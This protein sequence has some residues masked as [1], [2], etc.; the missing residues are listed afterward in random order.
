MEILNVYVLVVILRGLFVHTFNVTVNRKDCNTV[1]EVKLL[2]KNSETD[3]FWKSEAVVAKSLV[4]EGAKSHNKCGNAAIWIDNLE[5][6][7]L[8]VDV[9][10]ERNGRNIIFYIYQII[11]NDKIY[12]SR[13]NDIEGSLIKLVSSCIQVNDTCVLLKAKGE[14]T[15]RIPTKTSQ[16]TST[17]TTSTT[18]SSTTTTS[19]TTSSA[20]TT[21]TTTSSPTTSSTTTTSTTT[22]STTTSSTTTSSATTSSTTTTSTTTS[23]TTTSSTTTSSAT[24]TSTTTSS[25]TASSTTTSYKTA[26]PKPKTPSIATTIDKKSITTLLTALTNTLETN[27]SSKTETHIIIGVVC[28][29]VIIL[30]VII[31]FII[32]GGLCCNKKYYILTLFG[33][34]FFDPC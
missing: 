11:H 10:Y 23:S 25:T 29:V 7:S 3:N 12:D 26:P 19:T 17:T 18:T 13:F 28:S 9:Q 33:M 14:H 15:Y 21:S 5:S 16:Q 27:D 31:T 2:S 32:R 24:A 8:N 6:K 30:I 1:N 34:G 22:S 4:G 20:T